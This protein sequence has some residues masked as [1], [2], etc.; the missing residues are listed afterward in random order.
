MYPSNDGGGGILGPHPN[1]KILDFSYDEDKEVSTL[2]FCRKTAW[3]DWK[4]K[5]S[6]KKHFHW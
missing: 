5:G 6:L 3:A 4:S 1:L 2:I